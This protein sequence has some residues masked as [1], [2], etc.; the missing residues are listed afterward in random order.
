M[1]DPQQCPPSEIVDHQPIR[2]AIQSHQSAR[3]AARDARKDLVRFE[4]DRE[5]AMRRDIEATANA[6][7]KGV[8]DPGGKHVA[9]FDKQLADKQRQV[10]ALELVEQRLVNDL[11]TTLDEH[12]D[13]WQ[14]QLDQQLQ[15]VRHERDSALNAAEALH[16]KLATVYSLRGFARDPRRY[17]GAQAFVRSMRMPRTGDGD[18]VE[19]GAT[20]AAL[21]NVGSEPVAAV[22]NPAQIVRR[23]CVNAK[24]ESDGSDSG[25]KT[26]VGYRVQHDGHNY[27]PGDI[28]NAP[29]DQEVQAAISQGAIREIPPGTMLHEQGTREY[30]VGRVSG[31]ER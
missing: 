15:D 29:I 13:E 3:G 1:L 18:V 26:L 16:D 30:Q 12:R 17:R 4:R 11:A 27:N 9:E 21:R 22:T 31:A 6:A 8:K 2:D 28:F 19:I 25:S 20:F 14:A 23:W 24:F 10:A 7:Q 5:L